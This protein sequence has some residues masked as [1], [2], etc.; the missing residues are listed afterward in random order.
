MRGM[1]GT[2][3]CREVRGTGRQTVAMSFRRPAALST[4]N[5]DDA[6]QMSR[7]YYGPAVRGPRVLHRL[8][9]RYLGQHRY[10]R[11]RCRS[12]HRGRPGR[13]YG[14][15][16]RRRPA[17]STRLPRVRADAFSDLLT[18]LGP[19]RDLADTDWRLPDV[20]EVRAD[21]G[22]QAPGWPPVTPS[23]SSRRHAGRSVHHVNLHLASPR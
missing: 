23:M 15:V 17:R 10:A 6:L 12:V 7:R 4:A 11:R 3:D 5:D 18:A 1:Q 13:G 20:V 16:C 22:G 19:D 21:R 14:P 9:V 8:C 2:I